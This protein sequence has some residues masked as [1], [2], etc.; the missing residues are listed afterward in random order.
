MCTQHGHLASNRDDNLWRVMHLVPFVVFVE[1]VAPH[2]M[3]YMALLTAKSG[4]GKTAPPTEGK[5]VNSTESLDMSREEP[6]IAAFQER[7]R[8][9]VTTGK[10]VMVLN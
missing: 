1:H 4:A 7:W 8:G 9:S 3:A 6:A 5:I 2:P 10:R